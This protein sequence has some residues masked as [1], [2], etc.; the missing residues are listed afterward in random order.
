[1]SDYITLNYLRDIG[2]APD[3]IRQLLPYARTGLSG[4]TYWLLDEL[5]DRLAILTGER[6]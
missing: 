4:Q 1:V 3:I 5:E 6:Q 2:I